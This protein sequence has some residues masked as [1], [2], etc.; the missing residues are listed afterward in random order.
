MLHLYGKITKKSGLV[1]KLSAPPKIEFTA[2]LSLNIGWKQGLKLK[3]G[4][5]FKNIGLG[6]MIWVR[7][8]LL[9]YLYITE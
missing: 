2:P 1:Y 7:L 6:L 5:Y 4:M 8:A 9:R 3:N